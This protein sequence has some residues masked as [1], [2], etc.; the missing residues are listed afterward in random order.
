MSNAIVSILAGL[1]AAAV[2][3][4]YQAPVPTDQPI[5]PPKVESHAQDKR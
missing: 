3:I 5:Q 2:S 1:V 4:M